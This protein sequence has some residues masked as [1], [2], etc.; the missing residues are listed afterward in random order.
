MSTL[1]AHAL[2]SFGG[3]MQNRS[4]RSAI[5][6]RHRAN[7]TASMS[8]TWLWL[9]VT[10]GSLKSGLVKI[11]PLQCVERWTQR[12]R[13]LSPIALCLVYM[14]PRWITL[15]CPL[16]DL[17]TSRRDTANKR[18]IREKEQS[19]YHR[20]LPNAS[21]HLLF[22]SARVLGKR[23]GLVCNVKVV[24]PYGRMT[25]FLWKWPKA[26]QLHEDLGEIPH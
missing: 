22:L 5:I 14:N 21:Y 18:N 24:V 3:R 12:H 10:R 11:L 4:T 16:L 26:C 15:W 2:P 7:S 20:G 23:S 25:D 9:T 19:S 13:I 8:G 1:T 6:V 17:M